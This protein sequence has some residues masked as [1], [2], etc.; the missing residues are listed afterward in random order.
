MESKKINYAELQKNFQV[1]LEKLKQE[2]VT[3]SMK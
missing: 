1:E 2:E 3:V